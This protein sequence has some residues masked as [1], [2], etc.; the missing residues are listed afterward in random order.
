MSS[1]CMQKLLVNPLLIGPMNGLPSN[2]GQLN[3]N[4]KKL[5]L[6]WFVKSLYGRGNIFGCAQSK[7]HLVYIDFNAKYICNLS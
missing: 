6:F 4:F 1:L 7:I 2:S 3:L 5:L